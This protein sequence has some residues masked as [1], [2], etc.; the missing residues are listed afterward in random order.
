MVLTCGR[1]SLSTPSIII[2]QWMR[3]RLLMT[4]TFTDMLKKICITDRIDTAQCCSD[5]DIFNYVAA[6]A[7]STTQ[8]E[9]VGPG[10]ITWHQSKDMEAVIV[11]RRLETAARAGGQGRTRAGRVGSG[12]SRGQLTGVKLNLRLQVA[13]IWASIKRGPAGGGQPRVDSE[14]GCRNS[15]IEEQGR[16]WVGLILLAETYK[17]S[18]EVR[19][20]SG[21]G[22]HR[23]SI[24]G[25]N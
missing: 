4:R 6:G 13:R 11:T 20:E 19:A 21:E 8:T 9:A 1:L 10:E 12:G 14:A 18:Y 7:V 15:E 22:L 24:W 3:L 16:A 25:V 23:N 2:A 5:S 17:K